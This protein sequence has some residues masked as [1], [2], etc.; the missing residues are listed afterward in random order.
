[1]K[2][3]LTLTEMVKRARINLNRHVWDYLVG[4]AETESALNRNRYGLDSWV[5]KP[6]ILNDVSEVDVTSTLLGQPVR[7]PVVLPPIGSVQLF[8]AG[9]AASVARAAQE[10]GVLQILSSACLPDFESLAKEVPG[11]R[12][13]QLYLLGDD[14]W[15]DDQ[16]QRSIAAGYTAFCLTAD[17]QVYSRRERDLL[18]RFA[19]PSGRRGGS[20]IFGTQAKMSWKT[21]EHIKAK[22][23]IPL[24]I[25]G[26][27]VADDARRCVDAGVDIV[28]VSNHGGRQLDHT[29]ACIDALPEVVAAVAGRVPVWV[30]GG[31]MRGADVVKGLCL[32]A[33]AVGMGRIEGLAMAAGGAP[34]VVRAL[35]IIEHEVKNA[36]ALNGISRLADLNPDLV[37]RAGAMSAT[38]VLGAFPLLDQY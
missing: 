35:E 7:L 2:D 27:N 12:I 3:F 24:I 19:P 30:D 11:P 4:G 31:F 25:K 38:H 37:E 26:V 23:N 8:E 15:L 22:F 36:L 1:M 9:G 14:A 16:I 6:R 10:F 13:Y 28:Y 5:F 29:R 20:S 34:A 17:T 33:A 21:V 32:G 18:K